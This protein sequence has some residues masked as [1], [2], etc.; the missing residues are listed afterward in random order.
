[1]RILKS[2]TI[3]IPITLFY[4]GCL[5]AASLSSRVY[6]NELSMRRVIIGNPKASAVTTHKFDFNINTI[7]SVGSIS[8]EYCSNSPVPGVICTA[9]TGL[10]LSS[11]TLGAQSGETGFIIDPALTPNKLILSRVPV[12][13]SVVSA[14]YTFNS[15]VNTS[16]ESTTYVRITTYTTADGT[17]LSTDFG[18]V[19]FST[20]STFGAEAYV[21]PYLRFCTG[22]NVSLDCDTSTGVLANMGELASNRTAFAT[23]QFAAF[24]NDGSG[25]AVALIGTTMTSG[26]NVIPAIPVPDTSERGISQFGMNLRA[27]TNPSSGLDPI[28]VG[29][30]TTQAGY[31]T[32]DYFKFVNG[33]T[34]VISTLPTESNV[35]TASYIANVSSAQAPGIYST[36]ITYICTAQF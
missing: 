9:P 18:G 26:N 1:M 33:D 8:F 22:V 34:I 2:N 23:S 12:N 32:P 25:Y 6:A 35:F 21:P 30:G 4:A 10:D 3:L 29:T 15:V 31:N 27:N 7:S 16:T 20:N 13:T 5:I 14:S 17:G 24:T 11:A 36:T 28:G 19:A